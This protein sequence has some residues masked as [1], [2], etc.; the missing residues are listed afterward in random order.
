MMVGIGTPIMGARCS[1]PAGIDGVADLLAPGTAE[2][3]QEVL[4]VPIHQLEAGH[5]DR[6]TSFVNVS[7]SK[8]Y[9]VRTYTFCLSIPPKC[10]KYKIAYKT[11]FKRQSQTKTRTVN[12]CCSGYTRVP[13]EDRCMPICSQD[14]IH[15]I[16]I[17]P[18]ECRC[19]AGYSGP[20]CNINWQDYTHALITLGFVG[21]LITNTWVTK[22]LVVMVVVVEQRLMIAKTGVAVRMEGHVTMCLV[23]VA[24]PQVGQDPCVKNPALRE[25]MVL[26]AVASASVRTVAT[27]IMLQGSASVLQDGHKCSAS[28]EIVKPQKVTAKDQAFGR[29][30]MGDVC[31]NPCPQGTWGYN[32]SEQCDCYNSATCDHKTGR[33]KCPSGYIGNKVSSMD[34]SLRV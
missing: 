29:T 9:Q 30:L 28:C 8:A 34:W 18:D 32:C 16:C 14:C 7:Y 11:S 20:S 1:Q 6:Y 2:L 31:A 21:G 3:W 23:R 10:S 5:L 13:A 24:V 4:L 26:P 27:V 17:K 15:G 19:E 25:R 33:C 22:A 12:V